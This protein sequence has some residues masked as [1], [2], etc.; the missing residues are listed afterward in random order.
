M[1]EKVES[2][3]NNLELYFTKS[4]YSMRKTVHVFL[5]LLFSV[6]LL[7][8]QSTDKYY[9]LAKLWGF[10]KYHHPTCTACEINWDQVLLDKFNRID[11]LEDREAINEVF[12]SMLDT[13]GTLE[14][15][16]GTL[17]EVA[18]PKLNNLDLD[19]IAD[20]YWSAEATQKLSLIKSKMR[21]RPQCTIQPRF[22]NG[23]LDF[24]ND[25]Q[26]ANQTFSDYPTRNLRFLAVARW[27]NI[28][29]YFFPYKYQT[30]EAWDEVLLNYTLPVLDATDG[31][32]YHIAMKTFTAQIDDAHAFYRNSLYSERVRGQFFPPFNARY[33][34]NEVVITQTLSNT[35]IQVGD[36]LQE[37]DG[38]SIE[39]L[40]EQYWALI[41][42]S[43]AASKWRNFITFILLGPPEASTAT[44]EKA[45]G[46]VVEFN[47]NRGATNNSR[48]FVESTEPSYRKV[49]TQEGCEV[50]YVDMGTLE[51]EEVPG[52]FELFRDLPGIILDIRNYPNGTMWTMV[53]F[54]V[55]G[56]H[57]FSNITNP[58][59][60]VPGRFN[61]REHAIPGGNFNS[62]LYN[63]KLVMLFDERTQSQ[64]E[65]TIMGLEPN[66]GGTMKIGSQTAGADGN[67]ST[68]FLPGNIEV[69]FSGLGIYYPDNRETQ[70]IGIV[71]DIELKPTINGIR[72][73]RDE[74]LEYALQCEHFGVS[75]SGPIDISVSL[76][77]NPAPE[78]LQVTINIDRLFT[79]TIFNA[80]GQQV[81]GPIIEN[82]VNS[83]DVNLRRFASGIYFLQITDDASTKKVIRFVKS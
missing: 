40:K 19:W 79:L 1:V 65:F 31:V 27:W 21:P 26:F 30:D 44:V 50:G 64:A 53:P 59:I 7:Q 3:K 12:L 14:E 82:G 20:E 75:H 62:Q 51:R 9:Y 78:I 35:D 29:E 49:L 76:A 67:V 28:I 41:E 11:T 47:F 43:N 17:P 57:Y 52:M 80:V 23:N 72:T 46:K 6:F 58:D 33:I 68:V 2:R 66:P 24:E 38:Q 8:A 70:R 81:Q 56:D 77:P 55:N 60:E 25:N 83:I 74:L 13:L 15:E 61:L 5:C 73:G 42:G 34:E 22:S 10:A 39:A 63:G 54:L 4:K 18:D 16:V 32:S 36:I 71:P 37:I 48:L 45:A 69:L